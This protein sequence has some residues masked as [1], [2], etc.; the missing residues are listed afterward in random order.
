MASRSVTPFTSTP[1]LFGE[2]SLLSIHREMNRLL[3]E[4]FRGVS[5][6]LGSSSAASF[7]SPQ[8]DV[9]DVDGELRITADLPGVTQQDVDL[10]LDGDILTFSG[11]RKSSREQKE[12]NYK[13]VERT[14]GRFQRRLQ[15][16][17]APDPSQISAQFENGELTIRIP[18]SAQQQSSHRIQVQSG[19][20][21]NRS[22][23]AGNAVEATSESDGKG[24]TGQSSNRGG[25][26]GQSSG[27]AA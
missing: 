6:A 26:N 16:P 2:P 17:F 27:A 11:E 24:A 22:I 4:A 19:G 12:A 3:D 13:F 8:V 21:A 1:S 15:L 5:P 23:E 25:Q 9:E 20:S 14:Q 7:F 10:Q 18:K